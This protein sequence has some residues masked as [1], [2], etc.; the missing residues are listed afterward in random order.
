M[1]TAAVEHYQRQQDNT[2]RAAAAAARLWIRELDPFDIDGSFHAGLGA[3]LVKQVTARQLAAVRGVDEYTDEVLSTQ[4]LDTDRA[5]SVNPRGLVGQAA[6]GRSL[7]TLLYEPVIAVKVALLERQT[8]EQAVRTGLASLTR[9]VT[10]EV[11]DAGRIAAG[12][13]LTARPAVDGY[14]RMLNTPSCPR[15]A[16]LAGKFFRWNAGFLRHPRC[17][18]RHVPS[19]EDIAGDLR[20]DPE[21]AIR[22][23]QVTGLSKADLQAIQDGA[24]AGQVINAH[25]GMYTADVFGK[26]IKGTLEGTTKRGLGAARMRASFEK[27]SGQRYRR[28]TSPRL[29]PES[30][31]RFAEGDRGEALRLLRRFGYLL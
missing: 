21:A 25:R 17:D 28:A 26:H 13:S 29:R 22:A 23:G 24:D 20:T 2:R 19:R 12:I 10:T 4:V 31:Y 27:V 15:C 7:E 11:S 14:V 5:G 9:I 6:D 8:R 3:T 18:C 30:I 1:L 16:I